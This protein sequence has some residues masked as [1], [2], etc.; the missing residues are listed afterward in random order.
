M[1]P[2]LAI[3]SQD[4]VAKK[5]EEIASPDGSKIK[6]REL[7]SQYGMDVLF[8]RCKNICGA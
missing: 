5:G 2:V 3:L 4:P 1:L 6:V 8:I 7:R